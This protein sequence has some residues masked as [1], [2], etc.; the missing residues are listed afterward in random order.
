[1]SNHD[2]FFFFF[3]D[4]IIFVSIVYN[5]AKFPLGNDQCNQSAH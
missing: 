1:M 3:C 5:R 4:E 2:F